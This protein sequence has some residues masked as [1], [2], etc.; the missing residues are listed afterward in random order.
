M[1]G[2]MADVAKI[3]ETEVKLPPGVSYAFVGQAENFKE[4]IGN[5]IMAMGLGI[6]FIFLVLASLYESFVTPFTIMLV[7][8]LAA[9]GA[10]FALLITRASLDIFFDD[11]LYYADGYCN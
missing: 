1:G 8:P 7:L 5:M 9:C 4:L 11:W 2:V 6:L 10:F 3:F